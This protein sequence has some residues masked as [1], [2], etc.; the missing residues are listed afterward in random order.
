M[1]WIERL[2][3][4]LDNASPLPWHLGTAGYVGQPDFPI[5]SPA[6]GAPIADFNGRPGA[7]EKDLADATL[8]ADAINALPALLA[9]ARALKETTTFMAYSYANVP[10][11][12][13]RPHW[14]P[15]TSGR[16]EATCGGILHVQDMARA[17]LADLNWEVGP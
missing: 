15:Y 17:A 10:E 16:H 7:P 14:C 5:V 2:Q 4:E 12:G 9:A 11:D 13:S 1:K 6:I 3:I 8:I